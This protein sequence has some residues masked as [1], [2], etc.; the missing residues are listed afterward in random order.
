MRP[1]VSGQRGIPQRQQEVVG[2]I[3]DRPEVAGGADEQAEKVTDV[4]TIPI[5]TFVYIKF[6]WQIWSA[7]YMPS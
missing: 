1:Q 6:P 7:G 5:T 4:T 2:F 3:D